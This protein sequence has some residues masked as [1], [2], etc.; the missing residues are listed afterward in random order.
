MTTKQ[1]LVIFY[2]E[3]TKIKDFDLVEDKVDGFIGALKVAL[4]ENEK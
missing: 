2:S 1:D 3:F 4:K